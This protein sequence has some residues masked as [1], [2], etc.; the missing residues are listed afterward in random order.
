MRRSF[1]RSLLQGQQNRLKHTV[2]FSVNIRIED[3]QN[4]V[5]LALKELSAASV[6]SQL[7]VSYMRR[8]VDLDDKLAFPT[9]EVGEIRP[10]RLLPHE[11]VACKAPVAQLRPKARLC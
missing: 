8:S 5:A 3:A 6:L 11:L 4:G 7:I 2:Q 9:H 10:D 1:C